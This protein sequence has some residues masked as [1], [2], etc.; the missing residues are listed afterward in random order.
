[1]E[2]ETDP[3]KSFWHLSKE[4]ALVRLSSNPDGL[5]NS[6]ATQRLK[7]YGPNAIKVNANAST[8]FL[9]LLQF[10][11]PI[12]LLLII[13]ALLSAV[14]GDVTDAFI[15]L[16]IIMISSFLGFWQE[17]GAA[18]AVSKLLKMVQLHCSVIRD[19]EIKEIPIEEL[20]PGDLVFL[21][22]GDIVPGDALL[23]ESHELFVDEAAFTG[24]TYPV[25]KECY[26]LPED[27][28]LAKRV[29]SLFMGSHIISGKATALIFETGKR[30]EFGAISSGLSGIPETD[31][32]RGIR[33]FGYLLMEITLLL[34]IIIFAINVLL[35]KPVLDSF[36]FS[37]A[38]AVGLTPQLLPAIVSVNLSIGAKRMAKQQVIVKRLSSIENLGSMNI[39]CSD[40]TGTITEGEV[41]LKDS[42]DSQGN[43]SDK[44]L[45]Y[46][47]LNASLQQGFRNPIDSAICNSYKD[48]ASTFTM[49]SEIPYDFI[50]KR[51]SV[52][53]KNETESLIITKGALN[54]VLSICNQ[55]E[56]QEGKIGNIEN[57]KASIHQQYQQLSDAGFRTLGLAYKRVDG[58][59][60]ITKEDEAM[61]IFLGFIVLF[62][63][64]KSDVALTIDSLNRLGVKLKI[65]TGDNALV[66]KSLVS[67]IGFKSPKILT[68]SEIQKMTNAALRH[69][70]SST[71]IFAEMEPNHKERIIW[72]LKKAGHV[73]GFLGDGINDA[74][75][76]HTADVGISVDSAVDVA[77]EAADIVLL[78]K[79]LNVLVNGI[80]E[81]RKTFTNTMKY[82]F[83]ATSANFGNMF[84]MAG[85]SLFLPFLPLLPKQ[86]L[87]TNLLTD[88]P[89]MTIATDRVDD[90]NIQSPQRWNLNFIKRFMIVFGLLSSIFD[91]LTFGILLFVLHANEKVFQ[92]GWFLESVISATL[93]V[94][95]V[96]TRKPFFKS[97]P[98]KYLTLATLIVFVFT[99]IIPLTSL[100]PWF[101]F[102][103]I[104]F[105]FYSWMMMIII[106]YIVSAE[107]VKQWFYKKL[108]KMKY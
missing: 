24:E 91:Y 93:I 108:F 100:A 74:P 23:L 14:L 70:V 22:A 106:I 50:R 101:G 103:K 102:E 81:G 25:E 2:N 47:W 62:D 18:N 60:D 15:I 33:R 51:L 87:L 43:Q 79:D 5:S 61:M 46:A 4:D 45:Q 82:I 38:L 73:V 69:H 58:V 67:Q 84:S 10:K 21:S 59:H 97:L 29:N 90:A 89:E 42:L 75:A 48:N 52:Q 12:T 78:S 32:E 17:K 104:P 1:M 64:P 35:H 34:V 26:V 63:P 49:Q 19:K 54:N 30:T 92:T 7:K 96:R 72:A 16:V 27:T 11:S 28:P 37:L 31:F 105:A 86:I 99:M 9:L 36:L 56:L 94:L 3:T 80:V 68:G 98:G 20:V 55:V 6:E 44:V 40:K 8:I 13:A 66:A 76:L 65:I 39:L 41:N 107:L 95:V 71:N 57:S 88:F 83:M 85:A 77:K 53:V